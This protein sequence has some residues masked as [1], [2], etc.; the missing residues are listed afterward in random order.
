[1]QFAAK[2]TTA[3]VATAAM[4]GFSSLFLMAAPASAAQADCTAGSVFIGNNVCELVIT[5][6]GATT[7]TPTAGMSQLEVLLVAGGGSGYD[8]SQGYGSGGGGGDV[9]VVGFDTASAT[10]IDLVVGGSAQTS[11]ATQGATVEIA[12]PGQSATGGSSGAPSGNGNPGYFAPTQSGAGGGAG[13]AATDRED[14]GAGAPV[15]SVAPSGSLFA[16]DTTCYGGGG[17]IGFAGGP[18][19]VALCGAGYVID[20]GADVAIVAAVPNSGGGGAG[21]GQVIDP[22]LRAGASGK[23]VLRWLA[24]VTVAFAS[25]GHGAPVAS[26]AIIAGTAPTQPAD[27][28]ASGFVFN[29]WFTDAGLTARAD[30]SAPLAESTTFYASW[31]ELVTVTFDTNGFGPAVAA[32]TFAAGGSAT[33]PTAPSEP[34]YVFNGWFTD[35]ALTAPADFSAPVSQSATFYASWSELVTVTFASNGHG[36]AV[37]SQTFAAGGTATE[38]ADPTASGYTFNGW[39]TDAALR[40]RAD[41]SAPV[42]Q[43]A[44]FYA[45]WSAVSA[46]AGTPADS[47]PNTGANI[48]PAAI[49]LGLA[50]LG[51][52]LGLVVFGARRARRAE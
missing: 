21:G 29:G 22:A 37:A 52:G 51:L 17:A 41:F 2:K 50:A 32:Q 42:S 8:A 49:P 16:D 35:A 20:G 24:P 14:G 9:R 12:L 25:N 18:Y 3:L 31:T 5:S 19:G 34:G 43:S 27:P 48:D 23:I 30:F 10:P 39:F 6:P 11:S 7:F 36:G 44:T 4:V 47:M 13:A 46:P 1:M 15:A 38:P 28:T 33:E 45:S 40:T 26:Q